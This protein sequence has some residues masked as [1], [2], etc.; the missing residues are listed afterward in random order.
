MINATTQFSDAIRAAG[1]TPPETIEADGK[2]RR[3]ASNGKRGD[4]AGWYLLFS[5][6][7]PAGCFGDWRSGFSQ[8]WRADIGRTLTHTEEAAYR[9]RLA[10][11]RRERETA[12]VRRKTEARDKAAAI[13][14]AATPAPRRP[15]LSDS[16]GHQCARR[17]TAQGNVGNP[18]AGGWCAAF[19]AI[20]I[21][22]WR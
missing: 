5:D 21:R 22:G 4:G 1:L 7:I 11:L 15:C 12:E 9:D 16:Q 6:G 13:W 8:T 14:K 2:L 20:H 19:A 17:K 10:M 3:F 18:D